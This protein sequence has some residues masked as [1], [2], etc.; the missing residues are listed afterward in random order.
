VAQVLPQKAQ[1]LS[2]HAKAEHDLK[3]AAKELGATFKSSDFVLPNGQVP[4]IGSMSGPAA[5]A[6]TLKPG[7][8]SGP[9]N[10]GNNAAVLEVTDSQP[11]AETDFASKKDEIRDGLLQSKQQELFALFL[12]NVRDQ[13]QKNGKIK[14]NQD[15]YK[16]LTKMQNDEP[17]E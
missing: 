5:V 8:I 9:I 10:S 1:E 17:G 11:P 12:S 4:D 15:E 7:Q 2:D 14:I 6:F 3:K 16:A 13:M